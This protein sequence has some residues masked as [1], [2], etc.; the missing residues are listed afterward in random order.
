MSCLCV[1]VLCKGNPNTTTQ[2]MR[3]LSGIHNLYAGAMKMLHDENSQV[4]VCLTGR[5]VGGYFYWIGS[6]RSGKELLQQV[7]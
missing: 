4:I 7:V 3:P 5:Q 6:M 1:C 2:F